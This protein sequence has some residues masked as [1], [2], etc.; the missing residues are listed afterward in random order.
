MNLN[1]HF[2]S[3]RG[4]SLENSKQSGD[5]GEEGSEMECVLSAYIYRV[6]GVYVCLSMYSYGV[7]GACVHQKLEETLI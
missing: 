1:K 5:R 4:V 2:S 3:V 7:A 6:M